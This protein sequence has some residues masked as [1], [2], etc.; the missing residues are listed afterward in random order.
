MNSRLLF[1]TVALA[2]LSLLTACG[3]GEAPEDNAANQAVASSIGGIGGT[4]AATQGIGGIGGTGAAAQGI[5]GIGGTGA[6]AQGIGGIGGTG[7]AAQGIGGIGGTGAAAQGIGGI[8]GTGKSAEGIGGIG[9]TGKSAE[10]VGGIGGSG[11]AGTSSVAS[12]QVCALRSV[13]VTVAGARV[14]TNGAADLGS[15]GWIDVPLAAP[16]QV[17]LMQLASGGALPFDLSSLPDGT[18]RQIRLLLV[19]DDPA[20]PVADVVVSSAGVQS[21]LAVPTLAQGGLPMA[22]SIA[23]AGGQ[24]AASYRNLDVCQAVTTTSGS[25]ALDAVTSGATQVASAN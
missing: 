9:G 11:K 15:T 22:V 21:A 6:A 3:G 12:T 5:G 13:V 18:Y 23:V 19:T 24:V 14:N 4:G 7:A 8:G 10:S 20:N 16:V 17:D 1:S 25:Y 2:A